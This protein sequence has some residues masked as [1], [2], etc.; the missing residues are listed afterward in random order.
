MAIFFL[1]AAEFQP[2]TRACNPGRGWHAFAIA[3]P[4]GGMPRAP[5]LLCCIWCARAGFIVQFIIISAR[6]RKARCFYA[7][8]RIPRAK[9]PRRPPPVSSVVVS[10][11]IISAHRRQRTAMRAAH[12][13]VQLPGCGTGAVEHSPA[14]KTEEDQQWTTTKNQWISRL[15]SSPPTDARRSTGLEPASVQHC[16]EPTPRAR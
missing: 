14:T 12:R 4:R 9:Q 6:T 10:S 11:A 7:R 15:L 8:A 5:G 1:L 2:T 16:L 13:P 3:T